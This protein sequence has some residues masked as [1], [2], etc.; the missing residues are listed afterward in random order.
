MVEN[1]Q[2][3]FFPDIS[4]EFCGMNILVLSATGMETA[5]FT[6]KYRHKPGIH[7]LVA[8]VGLLS[9]AVN[10]G[11]ALSRQPYDLVIQ[12]GIAGC[13]EQGIPGNT[14]V[15]AGEYMADLGVQENEGWK[16]VFDMQ[17][18]QANT[19]PFSGKQLVNKWLPQ[20][21]VLHLPEVTAI[22]IN[23]ITTRPERMEQLATAYQPY[24][25]SMEGAALHYTCLAYNIPFI[26]FR[27]VSNYIGERDKKKWMM[28]EA[29]QSLNDTLTEY[30]EKLNHETTDRIFPLS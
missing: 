29:I 19:F 16:D 27:S 17:L 1:K 12:A 13:F 6:E 8:G 26:Q 21:N 30:I 11:I 2:K 10:L 7:F 4:F 15:V 22:S 5:A 14:V 25:E 3:T 23:E 28:K 9:T 20:L 24:L 18:E